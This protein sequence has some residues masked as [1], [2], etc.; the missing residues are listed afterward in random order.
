VNTGKV[1]VE[2][3]VEV[4]SGAGD[5]KEFGEG[6]GAISV[7]HGQTF[8][9]RE[10]QSGEPIGG[11][12]ANFGGNRGVLERGKQQGHNVAGGGGV[13]GFCWKLPLI[14]T[15]SAPPV[16]KN[17]HVGGFLTGKACYF[18]EELVKSCAESPAGF[19]V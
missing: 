13:D 9:F 19:M 14:I 18:R 5:I 7:E 3:E 10:R 16:D 4:L 17:L 2:F 6:Q 8:D 1:T 11:N 15:D 12:S